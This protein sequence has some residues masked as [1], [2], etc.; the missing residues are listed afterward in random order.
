MFSTGLLRHLALFRNV[1]IKKSRSKLPKTYKLLLQWIMHFIF[2]LLTWVVYRSR[3]KNLDIF[4]YYKVKVNCTDEDSLLLRSRKQTLFSVSS[5]EVTVCLAKFS[6]TK[7]AEY[8]ILF[9]FVFL[10]V[11]CCCHT[12]KGC[13]SSV[14]YGVLWD[15]SIAEFSLPF[16]SVVV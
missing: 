6:P 14:V 1:C 3:A 13:S 11:T 15:S 7:A 4:S 8:N 2:I 12:V 9:H 5:V 16:F 10:F